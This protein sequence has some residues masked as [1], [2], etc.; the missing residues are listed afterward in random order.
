MKAIAAHLPRWA[1]TLSARP[2]FSFLRLCELRGDPLVALQ[3][4]AEARPA[5]DRAAGR[6]GRVRSGDE[7]VAQTLMGAF[8][9][10]MI[11]PGSQQVGQVAEPKDDEVVEAV[12]AVLIFRL[13]WGVLRVLLACVLTGLAWQVVIGDLI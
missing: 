6:L 9:M 13:H 1:E 11:D 2:E 7:P 12:A 4:A 8:P 5:A 3:H 10:I